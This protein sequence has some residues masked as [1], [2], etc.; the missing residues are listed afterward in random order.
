MVR[1]KLRRL[2]GACSAA[3]AVA[4][5][6][7]APASA[8]FSLPPCGGGEIQG[9]GATF[10]TNAHN[11]WGPNF[12]IGC[13]PPGT[14][15]VG[16]DST[17]SGTGRTRFLNR[18]F[19]QAAFAG[20][21]EAPGDASGAA[22]RDLVT[23]IEAGPSGTDDGV[24][25]T[26]P[27]TASSIAVIVNLPDGCT[28]DTPVS[29]SDP[30]PALEKNDVENVYAG[31]VDNW[32]QLDAV[33]GTD[34]DCNVAINRVVRFD[35]SGTTFE[36]KKFLETVDA[37]H[38]DTTDW[39]GLANTAWPDTTVNAGVAGG[40]ALAEKVA[41]D[42]GSIGYVVLGDA[43]DEGFQR[44]TATDDTY[45][46]ALRSGAPTSTTNPFV[47]PS[48]AGVTSSTKG[49][50]CDQ[51]EYVQNNGD[52]FP[53]TTQSEP[54]WS[55]VVGFNSSNG[56]SICA[57]TYVLAW[58]DALDVED[59]N[60]VITESRQRTVRDY[61]DY[62]LSDAGQADAVSEDYSALPDGDPMSEPDVL[63][64]AL[65]GAGRVCWN[66]DDDTTPCS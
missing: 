47:D 59:P 19:D 4:A 35:S 42:D 1:S 22:A 20:T 60:S 41:T 23:G 3:A 66:M 39:P 26:I 62:I 7:A 65:A 17:G 16:Y 31:D 12:E 38:G 55:R 57:L 48:E 49:A 30:R 58:R 21:D 27:V 56:Y 44:D 50:D 36:F 45:W 24:L 15:S 29:G 8:D 13:T 37:A 64:T 53:A 9:S 10:Q 43:R 32:S 14:A 28:V 46:L 52:P 5:V 2:A 18:N 54:D 63:G 33:D 40:P 51:A 34:A 6:S 25:E 61:L 11:V